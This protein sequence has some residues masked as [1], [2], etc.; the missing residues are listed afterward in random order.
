MTDSLTAP[1]DRPLLLV[2]L[3]GS[4][5]A[6]AVLPYVARL[7]TAVDARV[8][9]LHVLETDAP[10]E[11]H[12]ESHLV[13]ADPAHTYLASA[14]NRL[15]DS[16][17]TSIDAHVHDNRE[18]DV[19]KA[20]VDHAEEYGARLIVLANHGSGGWREFFFGTIAQ[21]VIR[22]GTLSVVMIPVRE[23]LDVGTPLAV[24]RPLTSIALASGTGE[25]TEPA[26]T[27]VTW[28][29]RAF[30][31][32]VHLIAVVETLGSMNARD[33]AISSL[34]PSAAREV[35]AIQE[36]A[37]RD[38]LAATI[39]AFARGNVAADG[40][41]LRGDPAEAIVAEATRIGA[42]LLALA[43]HG[44][45]ELTGIWTTSVGSRVLATYGRPLLLVPDMRG[46]R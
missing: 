15:R 16:G 5:L 23:R 3:D 8:L 43:T 36:E 30:G 20:I 27:D 19:A 7:A 10:R 22:H 1:T 6:E 41:V 31:V 25:G 44:H 18:R 35:L 42:G 4:R 29:A 28:L 34:V 21:Q 11:V 17:V 26:F 40:V 13:E 2:P 32:G 14:A 38:R 12:G 37:V 33:R 24:T 39:A 46:K 9:L 45:S